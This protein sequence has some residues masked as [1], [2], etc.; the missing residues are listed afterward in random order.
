MPLSSHFCSIIKHGWSFL[1]WLACSLVFSR[2]GCFYAMKTWIWYS[3]TNLMPSTVWS[4]VF[5]PPY[6]RLV[7]ITSRKLSHFCGKHKE[8]S[9]T[10][11]MK[12]LAN[13]SLI[14]SLMISLRKR[15]RL[16]SNRKRIEESDIFSYNSTTNRVFDSCFPEKPS[17]RSNLIVAFFG[18]S[19]GR[20][21]AHTR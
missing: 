20:I 15:R 1:Q 9:S 12:E 10:R 7:G 8:K 13:S 16:P 14:G 5:G 3:T 21:V 4:F 6:S 19:E 17:A 2:Y 18:F 11:M